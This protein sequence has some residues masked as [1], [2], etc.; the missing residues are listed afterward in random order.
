MI[1]TVR[2]RIQLSPRQAEHVRRK[3]FEI[4]KTDNLN[5][6]TIF[7]FV[8][9]EAPIGS[10]SRNVNVFINDSDEC[11]MELSLP[12]FAFGHNVYMLYP[13][14]VP[15][16]L[17]KLYRKLREFFGDFPII[18]E[19]E[20]MRI[21]LCYSWKLRTH[22]A[23]VRVMELLQK[24]EAARKNKYTYGS[25]VMYKGKQL[26]MK[27]YLKDDEFYTHDFRELKKLGHQDLAVELYNASQGVLRFEV[28]LRKTALVRNFC[29]GKETRIWAYFKE[30]FTTP[31]VSAILNLYLTKIMQGQGEAITLD[32]VCERLVEKYGKKQ[33]FHLY[34]FYKT[35]FGEENGRTKIKRYLHR[36]TIWRNLK[37]LKDAHVGIAIDNL[38][39]DFELLIP[40]KN[41]VNFPP[42]R[43]SGRGVFS[44]TP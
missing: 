32:V 1:D 26:S 40:S 16:V 13:E 21:D 7:H 36:Q 5:A 12:K 4:K 44:N 11:F 31:I 33:G 43:D 24:L 19:W 2:F 8:Q 29:L 30:I 20:I 10:Y 37:A 25:S 3:S 17:E 14:E 18:S 41:A 23:S 22:E 39:E 15:E 34:G 28:T 27:F 35:Y 38:P 6:R 42:P 9:N